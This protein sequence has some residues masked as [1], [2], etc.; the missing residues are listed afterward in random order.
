MIIS[1]LKLAVK[2]K[3]Q[4][5]TSG[6]LKYNL[7]YSVN[8]KKDQKTKNLLS[9]DQNKHIVMLKADRTIEYEKETKEGY[10]RLNKIEIRKC[11][12]ADDVGTSAA[13]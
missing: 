2:N 9:K 13:K 12:N 5:V 7:N 10:Y 3:I 8:Q 11:V 1:K 4:Y 6:S